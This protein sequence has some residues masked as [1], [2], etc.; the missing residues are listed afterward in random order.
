MGIVARMKSTAGS[1]TIPTL[2]SA[3]TLRLLEDSNVY[4]MTGTTAVT[5]LVSLTAGSVWPG[6]TVTFIGTDATGNDFTNT[7]DPTT[8]G[9]M[10]LGGS[11]RTLADQDV[12]VLVQASDG[13]WVMQSFTN[14]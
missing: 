12:L 10:D 1:K 9:Q 3:A 11:N 13:T 8:A 7:N 5:S 14:N 2:A 6:R 4:L